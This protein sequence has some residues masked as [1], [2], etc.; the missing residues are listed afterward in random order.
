[1]ITFYRIEGQQAIP[2]NGD[3]PFV[4]WIG[5]F[6]T[7]L[8]RYGRLIFELGDYE[9]ELLEVKLPNQLTTDPD[10]PG[11]LIEDWTFGIYDYQPIMSPME[12]DPNDHD[13]GDGFSH[14]DNLLDQVHAIKYIQSQEVNG[15]KLYSVI[16]VC[17]SNVEGEF[18]DDLIINGQVYKI[19]CEFWGENESLKIELGNKGIEFTDLIRKAIYSNDIH[20]DNPDWILLNRKYREL[21]MNFLDIYGNKGSY[22]SLLNSLKWFEYLDLAELREVWKYE[23]PAGTKYFDQPVQQLLS[24]E[25]ERQ[26][27]NS[28]KT[29]YFA[30]RSLK[31]QVSGSDFVVVPLPPSKPTPIIPEPEPPVPPEIDQDTEV[32]PIERKLQIYW[33]PTKR[34][35]GKASWEKNSNIENY[36]LYESTMYADELG[37]G[38]TVLGYRM[39]IASSDEQFRQKILAAMESGRLEWHCDQPGS[40]W[41]ITTN[42]HMD[43]DPSLPY[44]TRIDVVGKF[45]TKYGFWGKKTNRTYT[46][47]CAFDGV[48]SNKIIMHYLP[49]SMDPSRPKRTSMR[50]KTVSKPSIIGT[51]IHI[52]T[53]QE[54]QYNVDPDEIQPSGLACMWSEEEMRLKM[55]LLGAFYEHYFM[56]IHL[57]LIRS[58]IEEYSAHLIHM[59]HSSED[60]WIDECTSEGQNNF[61]L[62]WDSD[63]KD[64]EDPDDPGTGGSKSRLN[65]HLD[66]VH[67]V[68]GASMGQ[69]YDDIFQNKVIVRSN[70]PYIPIVACYINDPD[71]KAADKEPIT[72]PDDLLKRVSMQHYNG[73]GA[74]ATGHFEFDEGII[75]GTCETNAHGD[76]IRTS[77]N[78]DGSQSKFDVTF[79]FPRP[80]DFMMALKFYGKSGR[81]YTKR[82]D[83]HVEDNISVDINIR[84]LVAAYKYGDELPDPFTTIA[85]VAMDNEVPVDRN[86]R[87]WFARTREQHTIPTSGDMWYDLASGFDHVQYIP[88]QRQ[89]SSSNAPYKTDV[90]TIIWRGSMTD[91]KTMMDEFLNTSGITNNTWYRCGAGPD[92]DNPSYAWVQYISRR[93]ENV[94][95]VKTDIDC[96][97]NAYKAEEFKRQVF[98][99]EF[100]K[101]ED[102]GINDVPNTYPIVCQPVI[103]INLGNGEVRTVPYSMHIDSAESAWEFFSWQNYQN[104]ADIPTSTCDPFIGWNTAKPIPTGY[105][106]INFKYRFGDETKTVSRATPFKIV[107]A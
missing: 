69:P 32:L 23:T 88:L 65:L 50:A 49:T 2:Y 102:P 52:P 57:N 56:P 15:H 21:A 9:K 16:I 8:I 33:W 71:S 12:P 55:A 101:L 19:G 47:W 27:F 93:R 18:I 91:I 84:K 73:I 81:T 78:A 44:N 17:R 54:T 37:D 95:N 59:L 30:L 104:I 79:L 92:E 68:S 103:N 42:D 67:V 13:F 70:E 83:V 39:Y 22:K 61:E 29:T 53:F 64:E 62:D 96:D 46:V 31:N 72:G 4:N 60:A 26:M 3:A 51:P 107:K 89:I 11:C 1:M 43:C 85:A 82:V 63:Q 90:Y 45:P 100:H 28:A 35:A 25:C 87:L 10:M 75:G 36:D 94:V 24:K 41:T 66:E 38:E 98:F 76:T 14:W 5:R 99:P 34:F 80:G 106:T 58:G 7:G 86:P 77:F 20:E 48:E 97:L 74:T 40:D 105:Y 6:S